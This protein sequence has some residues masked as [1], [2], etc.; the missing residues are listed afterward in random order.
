MERVP[1]PRV[2]TG[3]V[4]PSAAAAVLDRRAPL[5]VVR[6]PS[7]SGKSAVVARWL[8]DGGAP[9]PVLWLSAHDGD[10][11]TQVAE[12]IVGPGRGT[13]TLVREL[14]QR[15]EVTVVVDDFH[16][17]DRGADETL[18]DLVSRA[19]SLHLVVLTR[20]RRPIEVRGMVLADAAL[21]TVGDL[22]LDGAAIRAM[23]AARGLQLAD[24]QVGRALA[25]T[26]GSLVAIRAALAHA[27]AGPDGVVID[28]AAVEEYAVDRL[29]D[30]S[31][32]FREAL[33]LL[34]SAE[35]L[36]P[37]TAA[38]A[39]GVGRAEAAEL[40]ADLVG[41]GALEPAEPGRAARVPSLLARVVRNARN[42]DDPAVLAGHRRLADLARR[43][44]LPDVAVKHALAARAW[45]LVPA[46]IDESLIPFLLNH[47]NLL[48]RVVAEVP[49]AAFAG[50]PL[51]LAAIRTLQGENLEGEVPHQGRDPRAQILLAV[52]ELAQHR[53]AGRIE[54]SAEVA[55]E[56]SG[57]LH[58]AASPGRSHA[59]AAVV[60]VQIAVSLLLAGELDAAARECDL[61]LAVAD[62]YALTG[63]SA[64]GTK[65]VIAALRGRVNEARA[66]VEEAAAIPEGSGG[67]WGR[68]LVWERCARALVAFLELDLDT[69]HAEV[70]SLS[71]VAPDEE[72][73]AV[74]AFVRGQLAVFDDPRRGLAELRQTCAAEEARRPRGSLAA[75]LLSSVEITLL[76]ACG[77]G[78][79]AARRLQERRAPRAIGQMAGQLA[80]VALA[81]GS[82]E[83]ACR[84]AVEWSGERGAHPWPTIGS[85]LTEAIAAHRLGRDD[86]AAEA[87]AA[88][89]VTA[90][91]EGMIFPFTMVPWEELSAIADAAGDE[92]ARE[93]LDSP[94]V[95]AR[96]DVLP[97]RLE[98]IELT[99][100]EAVVLRALL[101]EPSQEGIASVLFVSPNTVKSQ[102]RSVYRKLGASSRDEAL[103]AARRAGLL[104]D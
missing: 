38:A 90:R 78:T 71:D 31:P 22:A 10:P 30:L 87:L 48:E 72:A 100:R 53:F 16:E 43:R 42:D 99:D 61:A 9:G 95:R 60:R 92:L 33:D 101:D 68:A 66:F 80:R 44:R 96:R 23:F 91:R 2:P 49:P 81:L 32:R 18:L 25:Q 104:D 46:V 63:H 15:G 67:M 82:A 41:A 45:D 26:K 1:I 35:T 47:A 76:H 94:R 97:A 19:P 84:R 17:A 20:E 29:G 51:A 8:R 12:T 5:T 86:E 85:R 54:R 24:D 6:A 74:I 89:V 7:G 73:W 65:A 69:A 50:Y 88:A 75:E 59:D 93:V 102:L 36:D 39:L 64:L 77:E 34:V 62:G 79:R 3:V 4:V 21:V 27:H 13:S 103:T 14:T 56:L 57:L 98:Q 55:R 58:P 83:E 28:W 52:R 40:V 70:A 37:E 11:L